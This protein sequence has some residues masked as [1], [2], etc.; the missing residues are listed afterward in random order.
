M[1]AIQS[2]S[3]HFTGLYTKTTNT[4][5]GTIMSN[6]TA[7]AKSDTNSSSKYHNLIANILYTIALILAF[8]ATFVISWTVFTVLDPTYTVDPE[9]LESLTSLIPHKS[10]TD[11]NSVTIKVTFDVSDW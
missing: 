10:T 1:E 2:V 5:K 4:L 7:N 8:V 11:D 3:A 6:Y 9:K